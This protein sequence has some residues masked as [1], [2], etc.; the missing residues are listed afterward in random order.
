[1]DG[2]QCWRAAGQIDGS[3]FKNTQHKV[4]FIPWGAKAERWLLDV[5]RGRRRAEHHFCRV[6]GVIPGSREMSAAVGFSLM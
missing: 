6:F 1:M 4:R 3:N 2:H 5:D